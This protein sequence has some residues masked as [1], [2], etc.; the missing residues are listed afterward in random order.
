LLRNP[1]SGDPILILIVI[2]RPIHGGLTPLLLCK[3][4]IDVY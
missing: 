3:C 2:R 1:Q 4:R